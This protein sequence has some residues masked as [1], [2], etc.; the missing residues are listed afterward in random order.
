MI[1]NGYV[2]AVLA[3][4]R[5]VDEDGSNKVALPFGT[6]YKVRLINKNYDRCA[7]DLIINGNKIARFVLSAGETADIERYI[8]NNNNS[9]SRFKFTHLHDGQVK[10]SN[11]FENGLVEVLYYKER[12]KP[13]PIVIHEDHHHWHDT[14]PKFPYPN[15]PFWPVVYGSCVN[16]A[17]F[18]GVTFDSAQDSGRGMSAGPIVMNCNM[19][20]TLGTGM[21]GATVRGSKSEQKFNE[22][23]GLEFE[24]NATVLKLKIVNG[25]LQLQ[26]KYCSGCGRKRTGNYC[27]NCGTKY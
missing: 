27:S 2:V 8:D 6:E 5:V 4:G 10:D 18:G 26:T 14:Y 1:K 20:T 19:M 22:V 16:T 17:G 9:G 15:K 13:V 23:S 25:E 11:S 12:Y 21:D 7:A 24:S 3:D